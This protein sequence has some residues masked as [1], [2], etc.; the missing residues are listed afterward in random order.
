[1]EYVRPQVAEIEQSLRARKPL[2]QVVI[3]PRQV[4]KSTAA[5]QVIKT[6]GWPSIFESADSALP[7]PPEWIENQWDRAKM[8]A[9]N[10]KVL[11][12]LDEIQ[13]IPGWSEVVK[14]LWDRECREQ[15]H[16]HVLL[17]GSSALLVQKG[18]SESLAG[19]FM[20]HRFTHWSWNECRD[21][22]GWSLDQWFFF[23]GYPGSSAFVDN[24]RSWR[25]YVND[26]LIETVLARDILQLEI[27]H[28][29]AL[30][31]QLFALAAGYPA[32]IFS[33]NKM[34]GQLVDAGNTT[35]LAHYLDL[36]E[37]A[38]LVSGLEIFSKGKPRRRGSSP[39]LVLWNNALINAYS[40][41]SFPQ[42]R[43]ESTGW[44]RLVENAVGAK[45]LN[46]LQGTAWKI[47]YW[48][49]GPEELDY[50]VAHGN[51]T[52]GIEVK[53]GREN[54]IPGLAA[55]KSVYPSAKIRLIGSSG[56]PLEEFFGR[57]AE[58]WFQ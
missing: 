49:E 53:S 37:R 2:L 24:E 44:G 41:K 51:D 12:V 23:G 15:G 32:Q 8:L 35:T 18:L 17:L 58:E 47:S 34:L 4:G 29:P 39:K 10:Q 16:V 14:R 5:E 36:L 43:E 31:R 28:K 7:H 11:L 40:T 9:S 38:F 27:V 50:V 48:R 13:K 20:L 45:L 30:L 46:E 42:A 19:R 55:F 25:R 1:V 21:A 33:Y 54:R 57:N 52:W 6:L 56:I 22:F 26:S 3:G